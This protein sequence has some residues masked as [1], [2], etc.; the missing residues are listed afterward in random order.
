M[1]LKI[2]NFRGK[3][4]SSAGRQT[5]PGEDSNFRAKT[6]I[7]SGRLKS[8]AEEKNFRWKIAMFSRKSRSSAEN[9]VVSRKIKTSAEFSDL[10]LKI[11]KFSGRSETSRTIRKVPGLPRISSDSFEFPAGDSDLQRKGGNA[12]GDFQKPVE[13]RDFQQSAGPAA[14]T[15]EH[16]V[17]VRYV[18]RFFCS[19]RIKAG[20]SPH[21]FSQGTNGICLADGKSIV[22]A[23]LWLSSQRFGWRPMGS[24]KR[25]FDR[26]PRVISRRRIIRVSVP[27]TRAKKM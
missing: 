25:P 11:E 1:S 2:C 22:P 24:P 6:Q 12:A 14:G 26:M 21:S 8:S 15:G 4:K 10:Q 17:E 19:Q 3:F 23:D 5:S 27:A 16:P 9:E 18:R 20:S 13:K 7:F